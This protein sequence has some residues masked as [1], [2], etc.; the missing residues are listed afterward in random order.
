MCVCRVEKKTDG[1]VLEC[2]SCGVAFHKACL[3]YGHLAAQPTDTFTCLICNPVVKLI[4]PDDLPNYKQL[5]SIRKN[6]I[7]GYYDKVRVR[8]VPVKC[9]VE[10][11]DRCEG[12]GYLKVVEE[13]MMSDDV[14]TLRN[15]ALT[16]LGLG[17]AF[18]GFEPALFIEKI[19]TL[20]TGKKRKSDVNINGLDDPW[21][22]TQGRTRRPKF[23]F[24]QDPPML[25]E[26][27]DKGVVKHCICQ[28]LKDKNQNQIS[29]MILG[30]DRC[31][32]W[33][34][35]E[36]MGGAQQLEK[37][38]GQ[39]FNCPCCSLKFGRAFQF[40]PVLIQDQGECQCSA[41]NSLT[42]SSRRW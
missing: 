22:R 24:H 27:D 2:D 37:L 28:K 36:C 38:S 13:A 8:T 7:D 5:A 42:H 19:H 33:F 17:I 16:L 34:H 25:S 30:C 32:N 21:A 35:V 26:A 23:L 31:K 41:E 6:T 40:V 10:I 3:P 18:E 14:N 29:T 20:T 9:V 12:D 11:Y 39:K 4:D 1:D 15:T